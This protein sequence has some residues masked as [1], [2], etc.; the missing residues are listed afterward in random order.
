MSIFDSLKNLF[1]GVVDSAQGS[2]GD[3]IGGITD[4]PI[5]QDLQDQA[6]TIT[7]GVSEAANSVAEQGQTAIDDVKQNLGL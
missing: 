7:G 6:S 5:V 3:I 4:N 1:G 2:A